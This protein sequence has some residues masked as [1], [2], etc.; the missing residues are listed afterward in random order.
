MQNELA[1]RVSLTSALP[2][3]QMAL[4]TLWL[5]RA[6]VS[7][8]RLPV[9]TFTR[10]A[11]KSEDWSTWERKGAIKIT[12]SFYDSRGFLM[13]VK[14]TEIN[15]ENRRLASSL[16]SSFHLKWKQICTQ[17]YTDSL[18][19]DCSLSW[20]DQALLMLTNLEKL[21]RNRPAT[22]SYNLRLS[23]SPLGSII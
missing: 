4:M 6:T 15:W 22:L 8:S 17:V 13:Q 16:Q 12:T 2:Q 20:A 10:P 14:L 23:N 9:I 21:A 18:V 1:K 3:Y 7:W 19:I 11:G 5:A